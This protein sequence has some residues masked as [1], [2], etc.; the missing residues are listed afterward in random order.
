MT[1]W[2]W[3]GARIEGPALLEQPDT[4][5]FV[6]PGLVAVGRCLRQSRDRTGSERMAVH[7][8]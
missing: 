2:R 7:S 3:V 5:I 1:V 8:F 4:T 6:D